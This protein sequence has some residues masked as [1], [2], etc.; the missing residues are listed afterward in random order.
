VIDDRA[1][2]KFVGEINITSGSVPVDTAAYGQR[3][4]VTCKVL[5]DGYRTAMGVRFV[6][7]AIDDLSTEYWIGS[8]DNQ[9]I[10]SN[11]TVTLSLP[12]TVNL[13][14]GNYSIKI[15]ADPNGIVPEIST[16]N[17]NITRA[18]HITNPDPV[19]NVIIS[20]GDYK[21][22]ADV[23]VTGTIHNS[24]STHDPIRNK[25]IKVMIVNMALQQV[26]ANVTTSTDASGSYYASVH[27]PANVA[28]GS[29][30][31]DVEVKMGTS[32]FDGRQNI[33]VS[34]LPGETS[35]P[36]WLWIIII[37]IVLG[38]IIGFSY[39]LYR[40]GLGRMV[41]CGECGALIPEAS[42]RCPKCGV[43]FESG[44]AKCS[45]CGAWIPAASKE[46]PECGAVFLNEPVAEEENE[47]VKAM[48]AEYERFV[49]TYREQGKG[50]LGKKYS[51]GKFLE[52]WR[53]QPSFITFEKWLSHEEEKRKTSTAFPCPVCGTL[54]PKGS[55]ICHK[56]GTVFEVK[57]EGAPAEGAP[58]VKEGEAQRPMRRIVKRPAEKKAVAKKPEEAAPTEAQAPVEQKPEEPKNP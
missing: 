34:A 35:V 19:I 36:L 41:E 56:C 20:S 27:I 25:T 55:T 57:K 40:Y 49:D 17:N 23:V 11:E 31:V 28:P 32:T 14:A 29:Y 22:D 45:E 1:D 7:W 54:N 58:E 30:M 37:V 44:T 9:A 12:W 47:Y 21:P 50:A 26:G 3:V 24:A 53:K 51:E 2:L 13:T 8:L 5:N 16:L 18:F 6:Y 10:A 46:C 4:V 15:A 52:W 42:K 39:Y 48:R 43:A 38:T 33:H